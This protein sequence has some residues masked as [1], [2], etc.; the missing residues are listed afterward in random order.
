[1]NGYFNTT[2]DLSETATRVPAA[3]ANAFAV[4]G[5]RNTDGTVSSFVGWPYVISAYSIGAG[6]TAAQVASYHTALTAFLAALGR[7]TT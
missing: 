6:M 7:A 5:F 2:S 3:N 4:F 1:M